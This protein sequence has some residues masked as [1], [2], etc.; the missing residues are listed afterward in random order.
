MSNL[1]DDIF[2]AIFLVACE[3]HVFD[4]ADYYGIVVYSIY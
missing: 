2:Q 1:L 3:I 4:I